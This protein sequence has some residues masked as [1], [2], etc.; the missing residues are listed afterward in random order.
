MYY[1]YFT[2]I[3]RS[4]IFSSTLV[5]DLDSYHFAKLLCQQNIIL[6]NYICSKQVKAA[7]GECQSNVL[8]AQADSLQK[9]VTAGISPIRWWVNLGN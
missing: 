6:H 3:N 5:G 7:L 4:P 1:V 9:R 8:T 2:E